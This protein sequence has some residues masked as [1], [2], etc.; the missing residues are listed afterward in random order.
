[1]RILIMCRCNS[2]FMLLFDVCMI[3]WDIMLIV[4]HVYAD[5]RCMHD[6]LIYHVDFGDSVMLNECI[7][8]L[9]N[10]ACY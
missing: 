5:V 2:M 8:R 3:G 6:L 7:H 10:V 9:I 4:L 1:M